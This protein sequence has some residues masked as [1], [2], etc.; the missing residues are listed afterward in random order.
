MKRKITKKQLKIYVPLFV[1]MALLLIMPLFFISCDNAKINLTTYCMNLKYDDEN[2]LLNGQEEVQYYNNSENVF[3]TLYFHLY[4]NAFREGAKNPI[5]AQTHEIDCFPN[6]KSYGNIEINNVKSQDKDMIFSIEGEDENIL[7]VK[8]NAELF[9][10]ENVQL[11]IDFTVQLPNIN[12]RFGYGENTINLGNFYPIACVYEENLGF[13]KSL[14]HSNGDPFY[15][16]VAN[17]DVTIEFNSK[18]QIA[19][20]GDLI[21][22]ESNEN[23]LKNQYKATNVR[24]FCFVL[25]EKFNHVHDI[26]DNIEVNYYGYENDENLNECLKTSIDAIKTFNNMIGKYP[27]SQISVVK[28]NFVYGGMEFPNLVLISD[29]I[30]EQS[31]YNYVIIH[32]IAHQWWYGVVGDDQFNHAWIDEGMAEYSTLLFYER[33]SSYNEKYADLIS[34]ATKSYKLFEDVYRKINGEVDGRMDRSINNFS[35][36]PEYTQCTYTKSVIMFDSVRELIG[37]N[38]FEKAMQKIYKDYKFKIINR[39]QLTAIFEKYGTGA[40]KVINSYL[41]GKVIIM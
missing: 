14:Y 6:G 25:S 23:L 38:K 18:Y 40:E 11:N 37:K 26:V 12:H 8:L 34:S 39:A 2:H 29:K 9:P 20:T 27:Y 19:S 41:E 4:P 7:A 3:D 15:S 17:Y 5:I 28:S 36:E 33:N 30:E 13:S 10:D 31:D 32:E 16:E 35:T 21:L 1:V 24:D 22:S